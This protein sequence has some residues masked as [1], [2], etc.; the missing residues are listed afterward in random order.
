MIDS[1]LELK[2]DQLL[3]GEVGVISSYDKDF[4]STLVKFSFIRNNIPL[5][6]HFLSSLHISDLLD[7][8]ARKQVS[9]L[10]FDVSS[11]ISLGLSCDYEEISSYCDNILFFAG[12]MPELFNN[13][14]NSPAYYLSLA[15]KGFYALHLSDLENPYFLDLSKNIHRYV[16]ALSFMRNNFFADSFETDNVFEFMQ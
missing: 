9:D 12:I 1:S 14:V 4:F 15:K 8:F 11:S 7:S 13:K 5:E 2:V 6:K 3:S 10:D 16:S